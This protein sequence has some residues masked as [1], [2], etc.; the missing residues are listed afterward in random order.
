MSVASRLAMLPTPALEP[1]SLWPFD[2]RFAALEDLKV[3]Y[4][5][6]KIDGPYLDVWLKAVL[7]NAGLRRAVQFAPRALWLAALDEAQRDQESQTHV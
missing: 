3:E 1:Q 2:E 5:D 4:L 6:D 7:V